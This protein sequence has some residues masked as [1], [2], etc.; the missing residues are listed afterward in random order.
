[1][2]TIFTPT[3]NRAELLFKLYSSLK[4]QTQKDFEWVIVDD[5]STD[6]TRTIVSQFLEE[7][8]DFSIRYFVQENHGKHV[9]V[10]LGV[11]KALGEYFFIV[12]SDD[13]L[14]ENA[15]EKIN[16]MFVDIKN[17]SNFAG[18]AGLKMYS[19][20]D[21][22]GKTFE[23][24]FVDCTNLERANN[25]ILGDKAEVYYTSVLRKYPFPVF[26]GENFLSEEVVWNRIARDGNRLRW[27][28]EGLYYCEYLEGG[29][30]KTSNKEYKNFNGFKLVTKEYVTYKQISYKNKIIRLMILGDIAIRKKEKISKVA[31]EISVNALVLYVLAYIGFAARKIKH[32]G[33]KK[34]EGQ[35]N[36]PSL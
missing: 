18:V 3:Y 25:N 2:I 8:N 29:L 1:M 23:G 14:P 28:N 12:D 6:N 17:K 9:A 24:A 19:S 4:N 26:E 27:Y 15:V 5:G 10:N 13:W 36:Y 22:V 34:H 31:K 11:E 30:S 16:N 35:R 32:M 20:G 33:K 21:I 7:D